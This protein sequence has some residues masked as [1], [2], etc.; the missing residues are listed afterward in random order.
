MIDVV[1]I[2]DAS[3]PKKTKTTKIKTTTS[4]TTNPTTTRA[5]ETT[6]TTTS[7]TKPIKTKT[8]KTTSTST[9]TTASPTFTPN[10]TTCSPACQT[11][12]TCQW[13]TCTT[14]FWQAENFNDGVAGIGFSSRWNAQSIYGE[15]NRYIVKDPINPTDNVL[16][17]V[18]PAGSAN[19]GGAIVGGTGVYATPISNLASFSNIVL[20]YKVLF[21][22]GFDF[23]LGG[24]LPGIYGGRKS[25]SGGDPAKDCF[26]TRLMF[27]PFGAGEE[28]LYVY[29]PAQSPLLCRVNCKAHT[30]YG[31]SIGRGQYAFSTGQWNKV[32]QYIRLNTFTN[33]KYNQDGIFRLYF[34]DVLVIESLV[35]V[36]RI[37]PSINALGIDFQ[38]FFGGNGKLYRSPT[39]QEAYFRGFKLGA[40]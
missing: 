31:Y 28:Y 27:R 17:I 38:T 8:P 25:C 23:V 3:K 18:Y 21:P 11:G 9:S 33:G 12:E 15:S 30:A 20:E 19:P 39:T 10:S 5:P 36:Y 32:R 24:K 34:N 22:N 13:N 1:P 40:Y 35:V 26:S 14:A 4:T 6:T 7:K 2:T 29:K 37:Q 16:E